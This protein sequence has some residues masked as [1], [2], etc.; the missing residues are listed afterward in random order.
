MSSLQV[1]LVRERDEKLIGKFQLIWNKHW[2]AVSMF[3]CQS[4][5]QQF[6]QCVCLPMRRVCLFVKKRL[7]SFYKN[8][9]TFDPKNKN[10]FMQHWFIVKS[11]RNDPG[12]GEIMYGTWGDPGK[13]NSTPMEHLSAACL[14]VFS[15]FFPLHP[16]L[17]SEKNRDEWVFVIELAVWLC[18][19]CIISSSSIHPQSKKHISG[20]IVFLASVVVFSLVSFGI[21]LLI[22]YAIWHDDE[23]DCPVCPGFS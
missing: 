15:S 17:I 23:N 13:W 14:S 19:G 20:R 6:F 10:V 3:I 21:G 2:V 8:V 4:N 11:L 22:G 12:S 18:E 9:N 5:K 7:N 16:T 1:L